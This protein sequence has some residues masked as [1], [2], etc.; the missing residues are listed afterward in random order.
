[1]GR[2]APRE[3]PIPST[4]HVSLRVLRRISR[5]LLFQLAL[6]CLPGV[7]NSST[8]GSDVP[9]TGVTQ[10]IVQESVLRFPIVEAGGLRF[11]RISPSDGLSQTRAQQIVQDDQGFIWFGTQYGIN[12]Y[13]GYEFKVFVHDPKQPNSLCGTYVHSLF[14]DRHGM[15]WIGCNQLVDR[16]DPRT[17]TFTHFRVEP[18]GPENQNMVVLHISQ[19][20]DGLIWLATNT[21]LHSLDAATGVI[22]HFRRSPER[23]D[24]LSTNYITWTGEDR[25]GS[26]WVGS[27][28]GL[29]EF[30][31]RTGTVLLH[32]PVPDLLQVS[33]FEDHTGR[34]W[35]TQTTGNGL[36]LF[37]RSTHSLTRFSFYKRDPP[38]ANYTGVTG[39]VEDREG[40]L[41]LGSP[42]V[43]LL[44]FEPASGRFVRYRSRPHDPQSIGE[45]KIIAL[46][47]DQA[48]NIWVGL[49]SVGPNYFVPYQSH[50]TTFKHDPDEPDSLPTDF[51]N[52]IYE[53]A[54]GMLWLGNDQGLY[55]YD[56]RTHKGK[57]VTAGLGAD[58]MVISVIQD[59]SGTIWFGTYG[60]GLV[61]YDPRTET[62]LVYHHDPN[63]PS[64]L[65]NDVV[66]R[67]F[68]DHLGILWIGTEGGLSALDPGSHHFRNYYAGSGGIPGQYYLTIA[69]DKAGTLW[70][71][72]ARSGLQHF[73][74]MTGGLTE[75]KPSRQDPNGLRDNVVQSVYVSA[76][77]VIWIGTQ[78]GLN[79]LDP[80]TGK[81][82][83]YDTSNGMPANF[84]SCL[85][86]DDRGDLW[87]G[88]TRGLS[89]FDPKSHTFSN[90]SVADGLPGYDFTGWS[91][92]SKSSRGELFFGGYS[93]G[94]AFLPKSVQATPPVPR[95]VLTSLEVSGT[96]VP[97]GPNKLLQK[98]I[99]YT[100]H[101]VLRHEQDSF[102]L[103]FTGIDYASPESNRVRY[104]M[105]GLDPLWYETRGNIRRASYSALPAGDYEF[106][107]QAAS[108]RGNW[109]EPGT[110]LHITILPPWWATWWFR[111]AYTAFAVLVLGAVYVIRMRQ[112]SRQLTIRM[113][114]RINERTRLARDLH[115]TFFQGIQGLLLR[116]NTASSLLEKDQASARAILR[117]TLEKSDGVMLEGRE[118]MLDLREGVGKTKE[119]ADALALAGGDLNKADAS[120]FQVT[121]FGDPS[122]LHPVVSEELHRF[123][124]EAL[125]NAFRHAQAK[126]IE[127]EL[128]YE[129][130]QLR[131]RI[132]DDGIGIDDKILIQGFR[133]GHW[134][135]P[136]MRERAA[137]IGAH[138]DIWS[139]PGAGTEIELRVP[140]MT[141]YTA[142]SRRSV[143]GWLTA[144]ARTRKD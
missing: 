97:I 93:G 5:F 92:C 59:R 115:D 122:P 68:V 6:T 102:A 133:A 77:G 35:I 73:D 19:D 101:L 81:F 23:P 69:E 79:E 27:R 58:P 141:A 95:V 74:P 7:S 138:M 82:M 39:I 118:L 126:T 100:S 29:D 90:Y 120:D 44:R 89:R 65:C 108:A 121:V 62:Y 110:S 128:H 8:N 84:V 3:R 4:S 137:K 61:S 14:K 136:G 109:S 131:I 143:I 46:F 71:G 99:S 104:K 135:L 16:F 76:S 38:P 42:G 33:F 28:D 105:E 25:N 70:L 75:Y 112:L 107:V 106:R 26:F 11:R 66:H 32:I 96:T 31:R 130:S 17:E 64:S 88:T 114:E 40:T 72:T 30:D 103:Q 139:R 98:A 2:I 9:R 124:R 21:G 50:F 140:A 57:L 22:R 53:D 13:D 117:D 85:V 55:E 67:L 47:E 80:A 144:A 18:E 52:A 51:V 48:G 37:D 111:T 86:E 43:G 132:R 123:G 116:F 56:R 34:F 63:D 94:V 113:E 78:N 127:A 60:H 87:L 129:R 15:L 83:G 91:A 20:R 134:G 54:Q 10:A 1:M 36:A 119:L 142:K 45:D 12:R 125:S 24:G 49:H 41:W